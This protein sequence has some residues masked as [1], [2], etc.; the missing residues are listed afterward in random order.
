[1]LNTGKVAARA[2]GA[3]DAQPAALNVITKAANKTRNGVR[4]LHAR[5]DVVT[6]R[7]TACSIRGRA[8]ASATAGSKEYRIDRQTTR[9]R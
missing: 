3:T 4:G 7:V 1:M 5:P 6:I 9:R 2:V 8:G